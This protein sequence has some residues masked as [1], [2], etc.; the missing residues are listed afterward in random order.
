[1][2]KIA[3][4]KNHNNTFTPA[5]DD[6]YDLALKLKSGDIHVFTYKKVRNPKLHRKFFALVKLAFE[7]QEEYN[8]FEHYRKLLTMRAGFYSTI[9]T[10]E[11]G[12]IYLPDSL[13]FD[14]MDEVTFREVFDR[15]LDVI[16]IDLQTP[17]DMILN[18][19]S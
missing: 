5:Y 8:S 3:L 6:D 14:S 4:H 19:L 11:L 17:V 18:E 16:A 9:E 13:A 2:S 12:T 1:M 7:N 15:V 10:R